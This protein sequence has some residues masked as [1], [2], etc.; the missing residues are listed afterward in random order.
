M[1]LVPIK[2]AIGLK[3]EKGKRLHAFPPFNE[4]PVEL[5]DNMDWSHFVDQYGGWHYDF[6]GHDEEDD[7]CPRGMWQGMLLVP[8]SFANESV[9]RWPEQCS[10][11]NAEQAERYYEERVTVKEPEI[12][13]DL[14]A[15]QIIAAKRGAGL[16]ETQ[17]DRDALDPDKPNRG[18]TRNK[19]KKFADMLAAKGLKLKL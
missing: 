5:R 16:P 9:A 19:R 4:L 6:C 8:E 13:E 14:E 10:I 18:R 1:D 7:E 11:L 15:L 2:V 12:V 17:E 3:S